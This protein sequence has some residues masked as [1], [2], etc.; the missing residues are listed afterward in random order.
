MGTLDI[1]LSRNAVKLNTPRS[2][3]REANWVADNT[4][5]TLLYQLHPAFTKVSHLEKNLP[6]AG[7][8]FIRFHALLKRI[9]NCFYF[10][11]SPSGRLMKKLLHTGNSIKVKALNIRIYLIFHLKNRLKIRVPT[12]TGNPGKN[13]NGRGKVMEH[14]KLAKKK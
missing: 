8:G 14:V 4:V 6:A 12:V 7:R 1:I 13:E 3:W 2:T 9:T 10:C 11:S 5:T